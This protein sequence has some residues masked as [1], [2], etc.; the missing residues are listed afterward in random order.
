MP[1]KTTREGGLAAKLA[2]LPQPDAN[3]LDAPYDLMIA[4][5]GGT[6]V[7]TIGA[8]IT[9]A[10]H[11]EG[12]GA[13]VLDFTALAQKGGS[14]VSH[15]RLAPTPDEIHAV[16]LEWGQARA[17]LV[18]DLLVGA[19]PDVL[20]SMKRNHTKVVANSHIQPLA[21]FTRHPDLNERREELVAKI[22]QASGEACLQ[23]INATEIARTVLGDA[24]GSNLLMLGFGWQ[25]G[26]IPLSLESIE[27]AIELNGIAVDAN[28]HAFACGRL[29]AHDAAWLESLGRFKTQVV[30]LNLPVSLVKLIDTRM[31]QLKSYQD[32]VYAQTYREFVAS[33]Q[34]GE[35]AILHGAARL[36]LTEAVARYL[37]KLMAYKDEYEVARL[38][39]DGAL[40][41][42][43][44]AQFEG[45]Y[46][47]R[48]NLAPPLIARKNS[49][50]EL[51]KREYGPWILN[52]FKLLARF[53]WL[54]GS[55]LDPFGYTR[56]RKCERRLIS[57]YRSAIDH[58]LGRLH[59][60]NHALA[61]ELACLPDLVRG[62]GHVKARH[63]ENYEREKQRL[64]GEF[65]AI[66]NEAPDA[67]GGA[68]KS[69]TRFV[70]NAVREG[71]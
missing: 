35:S 28:L 69:V 8:L 68:R 11:L 67:G 15:V 29:A 43:I 57:D 58:V 31:A 70:G 33:V 56:E 30:Q 16:R 42:M 44:D 5:V 18:C 3:P 12:K 63:I 49:S 32:P 2:G 71:A 22:E 24:V 64:L 66:D 55:A 19:L 65:D 25:K 26:W 61:V 38:S 53:K 9:M 4:G 52:T 37:F 20:G 41:Q 46:Q 45:P 34:A 13:S 60:G 1:L 62:Y 14:V 59:T 21:E 23:I 48:F 40:I 6:G 17:V 39:S 36:P 51:I 54:R 7:I 27:R 10:A 50:G 47:L